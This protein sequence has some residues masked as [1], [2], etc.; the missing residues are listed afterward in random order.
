MQQYSFQTPLMKWIE[1]RDFSKLYLP[2]SFL[3]GI[4]RFPK[5]FEIE[6][7]NI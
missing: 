2:E 5:P 3:G 7:E 4:F 1:F 6:N